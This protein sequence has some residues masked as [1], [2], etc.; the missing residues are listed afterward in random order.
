MRILVGPQV[1]QCTVTSKRLPGEK[2]IRCPYCGAAPRYTRMADT[3]VMDTYMVSDVR[4]YECDTRIVL[5][6]MYNVSYVCRGGQCVSNEVVSNLT[7][8]KEDII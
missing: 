8:T 4:S 5:P 1:L 6:V 7:D 3:K 2:L